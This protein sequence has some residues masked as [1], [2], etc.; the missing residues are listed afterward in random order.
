LKA[1]ITER[2]E[3][4]DRVD[5]VKEVVGEPVLPGDDRLWIL[6]GPLVIELSIP[7]TTIPARHVVPRGFVTDGASVPYLAQLITGWRPWDE[8]HRWGA[9]VHDWLY[10]M[11][12]RW[13]ILT[14]AAAPYP[15][16]SKP[17]A[18]LAFRAVL[19]AAGATA[20]RAETMYRAVQL[21]GGP[22]Y[23]ADQ[24]TGPTIR[25]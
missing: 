19:K 8:P 25:N 10:C 21:F 12:G 13:H 20:F 11:N 24:A 3:T 6:G 15:L 2:P 1:I 18:D 17:Y 14:G 22:A 23:R 4:F 7:Q 9:I 16:V 5:R